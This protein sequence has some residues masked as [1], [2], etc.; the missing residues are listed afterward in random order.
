MEQFESLSRGA[1]ARLKELIFELTS[2]KRT[3]F[4]DG[5][6]QIL[7]DVLMRMEG[8]QRNYFPDIFK[9][10]P[11]QDFRVKLEEL[12]LEM[13]AISDKVHGL[14]DSSLNFS[15]TYKFQVEFLFRDFNKTAKNFLDFIETD[16]SFLMNHSDFSDFAKRYRIFYDRESDCIPILGEKIKTGNQTG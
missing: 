13:A 7:W 12:R 5:Y 14:S 8:L 10:Q 4:V 9:R 1:L 16:A 11:S 3:V 2:Y 6:N 15:N